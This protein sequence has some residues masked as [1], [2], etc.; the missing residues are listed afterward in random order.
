V[1]SRRISLQVSGEPAHSFRDLLDHLAS[2]TRQTLV[3]GG[4]QIEKIT[5]P[6]PTQRQAFDLL[7]TPIPITLE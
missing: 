2:L 5:T 4:H 3:I 6:T 7:G 1:K